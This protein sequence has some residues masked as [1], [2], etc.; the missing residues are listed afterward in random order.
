MTW[1]AFE[2]RAEPWLAKYQTFLAFTFTSVDHDVV[3]MTEPLFNQV[4][5]KLL[6]QL[7]IE[8]NKLFLSHQR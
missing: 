1:L 2:T 5:L 7:L 6:A 4:S 3:L 8:L